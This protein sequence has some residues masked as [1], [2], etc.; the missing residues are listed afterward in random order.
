MPVIDKYK[1]IH[2]VVIVDGE[3]PFEVVFERMTLE[4][5]KGFKNLR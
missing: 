2:D 1:E 4:I 5:E 3:A